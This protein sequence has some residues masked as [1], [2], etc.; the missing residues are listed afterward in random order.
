[1]IVTDWSVWC[2]DNFIKNATKYPSGVAES[3][4]KFKTNL[5]F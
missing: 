5:V 3:R 4:V 2:M 1:M